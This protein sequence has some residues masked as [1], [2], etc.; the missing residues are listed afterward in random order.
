M[1]TILLTDIENSQDLGTLEG[2]ISLGP[3]LEDNGYSIVSLD[4]DPEGEFGY[5]ANVAKDEPSLSLE[6][7]MKL[8]IA[9]ELEE[10]EEDSSEDMPIAAFVKPVAFT[11]PI[12]TATKGAKMKAHQ[13]LAQLIIDNPGISRTTV[14]ADISLRTRFMKLP[15]IM[16]IDAGD[17]LETKRWNRRLNRFIRQIR[18]DGDDIRIARIGRVATYSIGAPDGQ[19]E[20]PF[21]GAEALRNFAIT[22]KDEGDEV[23]EAPTPIAF[24]RNTEDADQSLSFEALLSTLDEDAVAPVQ[25][26]AV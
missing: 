7:Q 4:E 23:L 3:W 17:K 9:L 25:I 14:F 24:S 20:I 5:L 2:E 1:N 13:Y 11:P 26:A 16:M 8:E 6:A 12:T 10:L 19:L 22:R 18:R 15:I 21:T